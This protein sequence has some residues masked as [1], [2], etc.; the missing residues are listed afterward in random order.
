MRTAIIIGAGLTRAAAQHA[1]KK[2]LPP[3]DAD[4]FQ[5]A[6]AVAP[7]LHA[8]LRDE[9][10]DFVGDYSR[11]LCES[12]ETASTYLY[13]KALDAR[14]G[15]R[16]H[17]AFLAHLELLNRVLAE[18]T[19]HIAA[20]P[21]SL[22]Y[23]FLLSE[24]QR[25]ERPED[26]SV[27][28]FNYDIL[29]ERVLDAMTT[30]RPGIFVFPGC[31]RLQGLTSA[32]LG[33]YA[34]ADQFASPDINPSGIAVLKL[35]G[36]LNW[37]SSHTSKSP[38]PSALTNQ[39]RSLNVLNA[40]NLP[41]SLSRRAGKKPLYLK[42]ITVPPVSGKRGIIHNAILP[43]WE[44]A[45]RTLR[46]AERILIVGYSC[47]PLDLEARILLSENLRRNARKR[48]YVLNPAAEA[49]ARFIRICGVNHATIY[50]SIE[51]WIADAR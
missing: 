22:I 38:T 7:D 46:E 51:S 21:R 9:L 32:R 13:L 18:T 33:T 28:T 16:H 3:L 49:A 10:D 31:Y 48:V 11:V 44:L 45:G 30:A 42:P 35:H 24:I 6:K 37:Q 50:E 26:L 29:V 39:K 20:G 1:P 36:S 8:I 15:D 27:I 34:G 41:L 12:L 14:K 47:P 23:R 19:N 25:L 43:L 2:R 40:K 4:Y 17:T 5:I